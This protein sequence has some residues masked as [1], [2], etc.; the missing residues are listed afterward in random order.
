MDSLEEIPENQGN[1]FG[2]TPRP[3]DR[4][5]GNRRKAV[6][7]KPCKKEKTSKPSMHTP[8][9]HDADDETR[10]FTALVQYAIKGGAAKMP[11]R[12]KW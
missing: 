8:E 7:A 11:A 2:E 1:A 3:L 10:V 6:K 12:V 4:R 5:L 9:S